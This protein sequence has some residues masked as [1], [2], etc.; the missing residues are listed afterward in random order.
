LTLDRDNKVIN[1]DTNMVVRGIA[2]FGPRPQL[3]QNRR[4]LPVLNRE[5]IRDSSTLKFVDGH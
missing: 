3:T 5:S 4:A 1:L 2:V